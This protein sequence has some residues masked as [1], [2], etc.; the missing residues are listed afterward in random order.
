[1]RRFV[2]I[3]M[4]V[5]L[6]LRGWTVDAMGSAMLMPTNPISV[7]AQSEASA[8]DCMG[9]ETSDDVAAQNDDDCPTCTLCQICHTVALSASF[10]HS[11]IATKTFALPSATPQVFASAEAALSIKPPIS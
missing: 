9:H 5:L 7:T 8:H 4:L 1:M 10:E 2:L 3:L 11:F 6:P